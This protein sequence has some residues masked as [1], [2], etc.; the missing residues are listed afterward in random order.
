MLKVVGPY[1]LH[2][3]AVLFLSLFST[4]IALLTPLPLKIVVDS[5]IGGQPL[6]AW[7]NWVTPASLSAATAAL[8][9]A[10]T[11][12]L[13][14][15]V[16]HQVQVLATWTLQAY[17]TER[18][19]L[20]FRALLFAHVQRL[21]LAYHDRRGS[22]DSTYRIQYDAQAVQNLALNGIVPF[23]TSIVT[24]VAM[25]VVTIRLDWT[26]AL[27]AAAV[28]PVLF[29]LARVSSGVLRTQWESVKDSDSSSMAVVQEV[30]GALRVVRAFGQERREHERFLRHSSRTVSSQVRLA[31]TQGSF[32]AVMGLTV[33]VGMSIVLYLGARH[34]QS[35]SMTAGE[36]LIVLAYM[37]Q[38][39]GPVESLAK[40][41]GQL[42]GSVA[43]AARA[44][45]LLDEAPAVIERP[46]A[47]PIVRATGVVRFDNVSFSYEA[48]LPVLH[49][50]SFEARQ[51]LRVGLAGP[52]GAGKTTLINLLIRFYDPISGGVFIDGVDLR[53]YRLDDLRSQFGIVLQEPVLFSTTVAEN[54][55][56]AR[57]DATVDE[58]VAAARAASA[59][60]FITALPEGY[61]TLV[62]ERGLRLSGGERQRIS[63]ARAFL[64]DAPILVLDEP[65]SS[66][67]TGTESLIMEAMERLMRGRTTFMIAHRLSTLE[68]CDLLLTLKEGRLVDLRS[69][70]PVLRP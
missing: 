37:A 36:L 43:G 58:I 26:L 8:V 46:N 55:A 19:L 6:P 14:V 62:G 48:G 2:I 35:G 32:D 27:V 53:E 61:D 56:Y 18:L 52:T 64:K 65:T 13:A 4:P 38:L 60:D 49:G 30:L 3:A 15:A 22:S 33:A 5:A 63:L 57:P 12:F 67:D 69:T 9:V 16:L 25:I 1:G 39:F 7:A 44:F 31:R 59:H 66:V 29:V 10:V 47:K 70:T 50:I 17:T 21:S 24:L 41:V 34:V 45:A 23:V 42:Q 54:I 68:G 11:T 20:R 28:A 51:G 40:R